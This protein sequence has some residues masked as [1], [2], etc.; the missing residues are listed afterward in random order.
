MHFLFSF[1]HLENSKSKCPDP[2]S[3]EYPCIVTITN[4][5]NHCIKSTAIL[6]FRYMAETTEKKLL[7]YFQQGYSTSHAHHS[8]EMDLLLQ[9]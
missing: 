5:H 3:K 6:R 8:L 2:D 4:K 9:R 1:R 7:C